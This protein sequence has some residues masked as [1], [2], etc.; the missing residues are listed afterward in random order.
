MRSYDNRQLHSVLDW[1]LA[2]D[3][4]DLALGRPLNIDQWNDRADR[5]VDG[6]VDAY[7][8]AHLRAIPQALAPDPGDTVAVVDAYAERSGHHL[9][10]RWNTQLESRPAD[11]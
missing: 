11:P 3:V 5:L 1:R 2:L 6:F 9:R 4:V 7:R 10:F 8:E